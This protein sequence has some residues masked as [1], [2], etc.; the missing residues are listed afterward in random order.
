ML[1][2]VAPIHF[3]ES[4]RSWYT[5]RRGTTAACNGADLPLLET[6]CAGYADLLLEKQLSQAVGK[7]RHQCTIAAHNSSNSSNGGS[8]LLSPSMPHAQPNSSLSKGCGRCSSRLYSGDTVLCWR[9][10]TGTLTPWLT[11]SNPTPTISFQVRRPVTTQ[12]STHHPSRAG[13]ALEPPSRTAN[14]DTYHKRIGHQPP[15]ASSYLNR[16]YCAEFNTA[17]LEQAL[18]KSFVM[19]TGAGAGGYR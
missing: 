14:A 3:G 17:R 4:K 18:D 19:Q 15:A 13:H 11:L 1:C 7:R 10:R 5:S 12:E 6:S 8:A 16:S 9:P 2:Q